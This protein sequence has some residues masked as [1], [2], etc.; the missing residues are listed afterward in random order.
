MWDIGARRRTGNLNNNTLLHEKMLGRWL[1]FV[2][3][4]FSVERRVDNLAVYTVH[5]VELYCIR[6]RN[7]QYMVT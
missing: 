1:I 5:C 7:A 3:V 6:P 4:R 2:W